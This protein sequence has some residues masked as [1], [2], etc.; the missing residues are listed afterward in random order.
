M[1]EKYFTETTNKVELRI[2]RNRPV[3]QI[4]KKSH[5]MGS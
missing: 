4:L 1:I 2:N 5:I 3:F